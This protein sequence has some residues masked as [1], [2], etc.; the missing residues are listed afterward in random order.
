MTFNIVISLVCR[1]TPLSINTIPLCYITIAALF[2][3]NQVAWDKEGNELC[4]SWC[5]EW[6]KDLTEEQKWAAWV[7]GYDEE[8][9]NSS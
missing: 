6:W 8:R 1:Q 5:D 9:W 4:P 3:Y 7:F 2:G